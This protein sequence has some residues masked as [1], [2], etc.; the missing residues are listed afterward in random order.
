MVTYRRQ[1]MYVTLTSIAFTSAYA[2]IKVKKNID[3]PVVEKNETRCALDIYE[4]VRSALFRKTEREKSL[5]Q[6]VKDIFSS[7]E[8]KKVVH[9]A[10]SSV[11]E[12]YE[13]AANIAYQ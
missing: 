11:P 2:E 12:L 5:Y 6:N 9:K 13:T 1:V 7:S 8:M 4:L 3:Q 10:D